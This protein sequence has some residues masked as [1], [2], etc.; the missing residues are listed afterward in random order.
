ML[1]MNVDR[2]IVQSIQIC[3][4]TCIAKHNDMLL[5]GTA[6][7]HIKIFNRSLTELRDISIARMLP[8]NDISMVTLTPFMYKFVF[9]VTI[10]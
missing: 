1:K 3:N 10:F 5:V 2:E 9:S 8:D 7:G 4:C 6:S